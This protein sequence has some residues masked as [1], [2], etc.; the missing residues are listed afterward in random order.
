MSSTGFAYSHPLAY[1][2][3]M[4]VLHRGAF[5]L[6]YEAVVKHVPAG[7]T[8]VDV[9]CGDAEIAKYLPNNA[10]IGL[11]A[12]A[13][14]VRHARK[15]GRDVRFWDARQEAIPP[16]DVV[17]IQSSLYQFH[18]EDADLARKA[19]AAARKRLVIA[20][21]V[22]NWAT[23]G[24]R[25]QKALARRMTRV[26]GQKFEFRHNERTLDALAESLGASRIVRE[27]AGRDYVL[28][29]DK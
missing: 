28:A 6:R 8:V 25:W 27:R 9:C 29:I 15:R 11:D 10:Y 22:V 17:V 4:R 12:N 19:F 7:A 23:H 26:S 5:A 24:N 1:T 16:A 21:P 18:P 14:F 3:V 13:G 2:A 20:E